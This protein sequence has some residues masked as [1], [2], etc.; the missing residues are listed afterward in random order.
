MGKK[1]K[2]HS[3]GGVSDSISKKRPLVGVG[4]ELQCVS[5]RPTLADVQNLLLRI[6]TQEYGE[7]PKWLNF[8]GMH[9]VRRVAIVLLPCLDSGTAC[10]AGEQQAPVLTRLTKGPGFVPTK[11]ASELEFFP[12]DQHAYLAGCRLLRTLL[13]A[14]ARPA[15]QSRKLPSAV[16]SE[17]AKP[18]IRSYLAS[19]MER[20]RSGFPV[21]EDSRSGWICTNRNIKGEPSDGKHED[22]SAV[23]DN[24]IDSDRTRL[25]AVDCEMVTTT[26][27]PA[28]ARVTL[29][30]VDRNVLYDSY[31][32]PGNEI[33]DYLTEFSGITAEKL[34]GVQTSL[35]DVQ[36]KLLEYI[37]QDVILVGHSLENDF[38]AL[39]L[40]H[41]RI[42]DT[43]LLYP[44]A[45]GWPHR[46]SLRGLA[47]QYLKRKLDRTDGH[48]SVADALAALDLALL[49]F[50]KG[51]G[52]GVPATEV[53]PLGRLLQSSG[54]K[55]S[56][57]DSK[58]PGVDSKAK[59]HFEHCDISVQPNDDMVAAKLFST[60]SPETE[61]PSSG[62]AQRRVDIYV[63]RD[64]E[65]MCEA[66]CA[67]RAAGDVQHL[68][69]EPQQTVKCLSL[70]DKRLGQICKRVASDE[71]L[72]V[73]SG[74][75]DFHSYRA[76]KGA[77][78]NGDAGMDHRQISKRFKDAIGIF[79]VG[80][81]DLQRCVD[82][83]LPPVRQVVTYDL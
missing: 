15:V 16:P 26:S 29:V 13:S 36:A 12:Q 30:G 21:L 50:E 5:Y 70:L 14:R 31:V 55:L 81:E 51:P 22:A 82:E 57:I 78:K 11:S 41:D 71:L 48:D 49:K 74:S 40:V 62:H 19:E 67:G 28:L 3:E 17:Q 53:V 73:L 2:A 23:D 75:G 56:L 46:N 77:G 42:V 18:Q 58:D 66:R 4:L 43:A 25:I 34:A 80:G 61:S 76:C 65:S 59:W 32:R 63:L 24:S 79:T 60:A 8:R 45:R 52:F 64:F 9:L 10:A 35:S 33:I 7:N 69:D 72:I 47:S 37:S 38:Q 54:V 44:H 39:Q 27:G 83:P 20:E 68:E 1:R 6:L